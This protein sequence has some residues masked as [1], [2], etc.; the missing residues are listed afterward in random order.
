MSRNSENEDGGDNDTPD[1]DDHGAAQKWALSERPAG[2]GIPSRGKLPTQPLGG[3]QRRGLVVDG[4][5]TGR[6]RGPLPSHS[7]ERSGWWMGSS[8]RRAGSAGI[9][10]PPEPSFTSLACPHHPWDYAA[11][12]VSHPLPGRTAATQAAN[13][14]PLRTLG[15]GPPLSAC[16]TIRPSPPVFHSKFQPLRLPHLYILAPREE[17]PASVPCSKGLLPSSVSFLL[18]QMPFKRSHIPPFRDGCYRPR[19]YLQTSLSMGW[20]SRLPHTPSLTP[21]GA[22]DALLVP[23]FY[24]FLPLQG[25]HDTD[26]A[27]LSAYPTLRYTYTSPSSIYLIPHYIF[28]AHQGARAKA[29]SF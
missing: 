1:G 21:T 19:H 15:I 24:M 27:P 12:P 17:C 16:P 29:T 20:T 3:R 25:N 10:L 28:T 8:C 5:R 13:S 22:M 4:Q 11:L 14:H 6:R 26:D 2:C 7:P 9:K 18:G 23:L